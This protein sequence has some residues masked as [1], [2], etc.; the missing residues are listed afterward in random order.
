MNIERWLISCNRMPQSKFFVATRI[1]LLD[2]DLFIGDLS[3][4][5]LYNN[6]KLI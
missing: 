5:F 6:H 3:P 1:L 2:F 4:L